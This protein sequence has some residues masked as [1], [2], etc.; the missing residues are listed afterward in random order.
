MTAAH[1][2]YFWQ[3][4]PTWV[5]HLAA[6]SLVAMAALV[7]LV[8]GIAVAAQRLAEAFARLLGSSAGD[9]YSVSMHVVAMTAMAG[10]AVGVATGLTRLGQRVPAAFLLVAT[11]AGPMTVT[12]APVRA[13]LVA[14]SS[15]DTV[16]WWHL[17]VGSAVLVILTGWTWWCVR[18]LPPRTPLGPRSAAAAALVFVVS[19][20]L[21]YLVYYQ[22]VDSGS[23]SNLPGATPV[24][25]W[26][27]LAAGVTVVVAF[28]RHW[29]SAVV[30]LVG[31]AAVMGFLVLAYTRLGGWP[32]VAGWEYDGMES[33]LITSVVSTVTLLVAPVVGLAI[34]MLRVGAGHVPSWFTMVD[35]SPK[36]MRPDAAAP[37]AT[38]SAS[39]PG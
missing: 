12:A 23:G 35:Q 26:S 22:L 31:A 7:L 13:S 38:A 3:R 11:V 25:G 33:P 36:S 1:E 5:R 30:A 32:G 18:C 10:F 21:G 34:W 37:T 39:A 14:A 28:G 20:A 4:T 27:V 8:G 19:M 9:M 24:V 16:R 17:V 2:Q 6:G 15:D 29:W